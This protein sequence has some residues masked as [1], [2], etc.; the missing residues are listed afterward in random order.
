MACPYFYPVERRTPDT[1]PRSA[2]LPLGGTWTG[3]CRAGTAVAKPEEKCQSAL[4]SL[5]Y[6]RGVCARFPTD[7]AGPDAVRFAITR[8]QPNS[9]HLYYVLERNHQPFAHGKLEY[10]LPS[11]Q[12]AGM[13]SAETL[14]RQAEAYVASYLLRK[15]EASVR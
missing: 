14:Q 8:E 4:C 1:D 5:G 11:G 10:T 13:L 6:A 15:K 2:M 7:D 3:L 9:L 12:V